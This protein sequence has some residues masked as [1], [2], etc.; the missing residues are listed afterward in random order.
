MNQQQ[1]IAFVIRELENQRNCD[2]I[3]RVLCEQTG[4]PQRQVEIFVQK[5]EGDWTP[6]VGSDHDQRAAEPAVSQPSQRQR[7]RA[8]TEQPTKAADLAFA[9][10]S[11]VRQRRIELEK[12]QEAVEFV[13]HQLGRQHNHDSII[14]TL[15]EKEEWTWQEARHFVQR[16]AIEH[17]DKIAARQTPLFIMLGVGSIVAGVA[18][19][20]YGI[21]FILNGEISE[22]SLGLAITGPAMVVGGIAGI[23]RTI[24]MMGE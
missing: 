17:H 18:M 5:V 4:W 2:D 21:Y 1:A 15:C 12:H 16:V 8:E 20:A 24:S 9:G 7:I 14:R 22:L 3:A 19:T 23:W 11:Q 13:I 10:P 6:P